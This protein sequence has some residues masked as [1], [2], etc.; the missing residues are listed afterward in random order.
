M[1][2]KPRYTIAL[3]FEK[4]KFSEH[5]QGVNL[6]YTSKSEG[7]EPLAMDIVYDGEDAERATSLYRELQ[8]RL[9]VPQGSLPQ[10]D[11]NSL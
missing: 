7:V 2:G 9:G 4:E 5:W 8:I 10:A 11:G 6:G 3:T 1:E